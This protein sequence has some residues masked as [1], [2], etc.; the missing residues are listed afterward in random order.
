[1]KIVKSDHTVATLDTAVGARHD[2]YLNN[3]A[4]SLTAGLGNPFG[5][6]LVALIGSGHETNNR[7][8]LLSWVTFMRHEVFALRME[9]GN[10]L[11]H[12]RARL[13]NRIEQGRCW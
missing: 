3:L 11:E 1:M 12:L 13:V 6:E 5:S 4:A 10:V 8:A 9:G 7:E 2:Q